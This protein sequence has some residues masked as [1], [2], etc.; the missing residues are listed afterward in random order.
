MLHAEKN[1]GGAWPWGQGYTCTQHSM[2]NTMYNI[3]IIAIIYTHIP[4]IWGTR[5]HSYSPPHRSRV[6]S[7]SDRNWSPFWRPSVTPPGEWWLWRHHPP[8]CCSGT[9]LSRGARPTS[10]EA[11][12]PLGSQCH[13]NRRLE[14][15]VLLN[16][17]KKKEFPQY[18]ESGLNCV[19]CFIT[20]YCQ[21]LNSMG[22]MS[23]SL[24]YCM[25]QYGTQNAGNGNGTYMYNTA[26][27]IG[28]WEWAWGC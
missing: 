8:V 21:S 14:G 15:T 11:C 1:L 10:Q 5:I 27:N 19:I 13:P 9:A 3:I 23:P 16:L 28:Y 7:L 4:C 20:P 24:Q 6:D 2:S 25:S 17:W 18:S 26:C 22:A 12:P